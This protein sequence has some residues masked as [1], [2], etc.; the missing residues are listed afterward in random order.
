MI[1]PVWV[2]SVSNPGMERL[3]YALLDTQSDTVFI[4]QEVSNSLQTETHPVRLKLTTMIG[5]D[6]LVHSER[7]QGLRVSG[8]NSTLSSISLQP[9][10]RIAY[11]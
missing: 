9:T 3:V 11:Q 10:L 6:A 8:F 1:V 4:E 5:K 7:V 2:S